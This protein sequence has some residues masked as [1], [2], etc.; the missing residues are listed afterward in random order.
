MLGN[1]Y[2]KSRKG[3]RVEV[4]VVVVGDR[5]A[6]KS[7]LCFTYAAAA[8]KLN[9]QPIPAPTYDGESFGTQEIQIKHEQSQTEVS[10]TLTDTSGQED[11]ASVRQMAYRSAMGF[12]LCYSANERPTFLNVKTW[13][14]ELK[15]KAPSKPVWLVAVYAPVDPSKPKT[16]RNEAPVLPSEARKLAASFGF[17][18]FLECHSDY[19]ESVLA[20]FQRMHDFI[21]ADEQTRQGMYKWPPTNDNL[22]EYVITPTAIAALQRELASIDISSESNRT[23][24]A[25]ISPRST[26]PSKRNKKKKSAHSKKGGSQPSTLT[27]Y[28]SS[29]SSPPKKKK[30][31]SNSSGALKSVVS[32]EPNSP[33]S[34]S[35]GESGRTRSSTAGPSGLEPRDRSPRPLSQLFGAGFRDEKLSKL[36]RSLTR[37]GEK[38]GGVYVE[39]LLD[40]SSS[41]SGF[42]T[43]SVEEV[44]GWLSLTLAKPIEHRVKQ[45]STHIF[46]VKIKS[47][48]EWKNVSSCTNIYGTKIQWIS[49]SGFVGKSHLDTLFS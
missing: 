1:P 27:H 14:S 38:T 26:E 49:V 2:R 7:R 24:D 19:G 47:T 42:P 36:Y 25:I 44:N 29:A 45:F 22:N 32:K 15:E 48:D 35:P 23:L 40:S 41:L 17:V 20:Q 8:N 37:R 33:K 12:L 13:A 4:D 11:F 3:G 6:E 28:V 43:P 39:I 18:D 30:F 10:I 16:P 21:V 31:Q 46:I 5:E 9:G 34:S